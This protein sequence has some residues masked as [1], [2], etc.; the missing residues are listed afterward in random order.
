VDAWFELHSLARKFSNVQNKPYTDTLQQHQRVYIAEKDHHLPNGIVFPWR[1]LVEEFGNYFFTSSVAWM[2]AYAIKHNPEKI[3][4]WGVDMSASEEYGYQRAGCHYFIQEAKNRGIDVYAP[5]QSDILQGV[6][7]Y[8]I[9]E[10]W[11]MFTKF[12]VRRNELKERLHKAESAIEAASR[13]VDVFRGALDDMQYQEN[14]WL[15]PDWTKFLNK[16]ASN[17]SVDPQQDSD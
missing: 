14:T 9:K 16:D 2:L 5:Q 1:E 7:L 10:Q 11:P 4:L 15:Q 12:A 17:V 3:G 6:P 13:D 8:G